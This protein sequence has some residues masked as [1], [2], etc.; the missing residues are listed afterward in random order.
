MKILGISNQNFVGVTVATR[1]VC[2]DYYP[3]AHQND[4]L[5]AAHLGRQIAKVKPDLLI[6]GGWSQGYDT[7]LTE[8]NK[9]RSFPVINV[10]HS[11]I[12]HGSFFG[13]D[14]YYP[15][16]TACHKRRELDFLGFVQPQQVNYYQKV[17]QEYALWVPH[18]FKQLT[19][20][21]KPKVFRIGVLG[22]TAS[23]FKNG[24]GPTEVAKDYVQ[25]VPGCEFVA[26]HSYDK[27]HHHFMQLI[28]SCSVLMHTSHLECYPNV[29][30]EAWSMGVPVILSQASVGLIDNPLL[31]F[32]ERCLLK[33]MVV[34]S[35]IDAYELYKTIEKI[36]KNWA[37]Y[38]ELVYGIHD[39]ISRRAAVY[40]D[41]L[42]VKI[43]E[44]YRTRNFDRAF[45][46]MPFEKPEELWL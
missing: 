22:G 26:N 11:T 33:D 34:A 7:V 20:V 37:H 4:A 16:V 27:M 32:E 45:F 8:M 39:K 29:V 36:H 41:K 10:Y 17:R 2:T 31:N 28:A 18:Y 9:Y 43:I 6:V 21:K 5:A 12:F 14:M 3:V 15:Q 19:R 24:H 40:T 42:F 38:S 23:W 30:Q 35:N 1:A 46:R 25:N 13:D 44:G